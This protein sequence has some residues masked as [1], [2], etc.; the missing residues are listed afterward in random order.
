MVRALV[1]F[2]LIAAVP[3]ALAAGGE[4]KEE[5]VIGEIGLEE[6]DELMDEFALLQ[7]EDIIYAAAKHEQDIAESPSAVTVITREQIE[8]THCT[9]I[10]CLLRQ[11]P[12]AH[13]RQLHPMYAAVGARALAGESGEKGLVL[14]DGQE[15]NVEIFGLVFWQ[16]LP[17]HLEDI[18]RIEIIRGPGSALYGANAHSLVVSIFT[19]GTTGDSAGFFVGS[20]EHD[21]STVHMRLEKTLGKWHLQVSGGYETGG[22]WRIPDERQQELGRLRLRVDRETD[23]STSSLQLGMTVPEGQVYTSLAPT[24]IQDAYLA[25]LIASHRTEFFRAQLS[26]GLYSSDFHLD[27]PLYYGDVKL[28]EFPEILDFLSSNLD[29]DVQVTWEPFEGNLLIAGSNYRWITLLAENNQP[30]AVHQ[31]RIGVFL[32]DEQRLGKSLILTGGVRLDYNNITPFTASPRFACVW[33]FAKEQFL[34]LSFGRAFRKPSFMNTSAHF[35]GV[36]GEA[37][38]PGLEDFFLR[39]VGNDGLGNESITS[40]E[41][42]YRGKFLAGDLTAEATAFFNL[43]RDT[44]SFH[45]KIATGG[46]GL[47]DL[48]LSKLEYR[49][50]GREVNTL[51]GSISVVYRIRKVLWLSANYTYRHTWYISEPEETG[52]VEGG[53]GDRLP[54][55]P[56]HL[57]NLSFHY[58]AGSGLRLGLSVHGASAH[59]LALPR[60]GGLFDDMIMVHSPPFAIVSG[61]ISWRVPFDSQWIEMGVRAFNTF[62]Q[63]FRDTQAV[64]RSDGTELGGELLGRRIFFFLRGAI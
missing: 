38:F 5:E 27:M 13:V 46:V 37:G 44:I 3:P 54:W 4:R 48:S 1:G 22:H 55:E 16:A 34:R 51:G 53:R 14:I 31:H 61:F 18:E 8:N 47:P 30:D 15:V 25:N 59:D 2:M 42:G 29:T 57:A 50:A 60:N 10:P 6:E 52:I 9:H 35:R 28:G 43:Y 64:T 21:R 7:E 12:E 33:R 23:S 41:A 49:N 40:F 56:A 26:L 24:F 58:L 20:G 39:S 62:H 19:R 63:G 32:H 11:V 45:A 36:K 17:I